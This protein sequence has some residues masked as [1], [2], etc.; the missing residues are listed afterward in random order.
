[1]GPQS[2]GADPGPAAYGKGGKNA[3]VTDANVVLGFLGANGLAGG[4]LSLDADLARQSVKDKVADP[5][6]ISVEEAAWGILRIAVAGMAAAARVVSVSK[7][8]DAREFTLLACG[9]AGPLHAC[10]VANDLGIDEILIPPYPGVLSAYGLLAADAEVP[11]W[12]TFHVN[13]DPGG[14]Q[15]L[16]VA[17]KRLGEDVSARLMRAGVNAAE[18]SVRYAVDARYAGQSHELIVPINVDGSDQELAAF[19]EKQFEEQHWT[20]YGQNDPE[21]RVEVTGLKVT[22]GAS[23]TAPPLQAP[24]AVDTVYPHRTI[25]NPETGQLEPAAV[26]HRGRLSGSIDG[27]ALILQDDTTT[28]I[29]DGWNA[30]VDGSGSLLI[31]RAGVKEVTNDRGHTDKNGSSIE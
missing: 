6:G 25:Y 22:A 5:L 7:G 16:R 20:L 23:R 15:H 12:K 24:A 1:M 2:A 9:G 21:G 27:P 17:L 19:I 29:P 31:H 28:V 14:L 26:I 18:I 11:Q 10:G 3:T 13:L 30:I 4:S 8:H